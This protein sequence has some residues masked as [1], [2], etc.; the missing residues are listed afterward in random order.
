MVAL[1]VLF[2][3]T[4]LGLR[5][6][7]AAFEPEV[8]RLL[9]VRVTRMFTMGWG[10]AAVAGALA[11]VLV[12]PSVFVAPNNFDGILVFGFTAAVL[13]GLESPPGALVGGLVLGVSLSYVSGYL[14]PELVTL[15]ALAILVAVLMVRPQGLFAP[16]GER[17]V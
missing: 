16:A 11:G 9:G 12:A 14:G 4:S 5:M 13:G 2:R 17:R 8:A 15:G 10:L 3:F 6:R 1:V 7:A